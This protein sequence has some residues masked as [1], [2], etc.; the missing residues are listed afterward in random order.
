[1][2]RHESSETQW[3]GIEGILPPEKIAG[4]GRPAKSDRLMLN[5]MIYWLTAGVPW[6]D[7]P[8]QFGLWKNV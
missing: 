7:L 3:S 1:M 8:E 6:R 4:A 2:N 5:A